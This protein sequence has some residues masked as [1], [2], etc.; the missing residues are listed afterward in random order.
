LDAPVL[1]VVGLKLG[2]LNHARLTRESVLASGLEIAGWIGSEI[3][4]KMPEKDENKLY[5]E[6]IFGEKALS[7][8][9]FDHDAGH[10]AERL[11][12]ALPRLLQPRASN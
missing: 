4:A 9:P 2:C 10:D 5:L 7:W 11:R 3:D 1:V 12:A 8:L 6:S